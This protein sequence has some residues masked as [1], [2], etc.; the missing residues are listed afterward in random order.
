MAAEKT[1]LVVDDD[2]DIVETTRMILESAGYKVETAVNGTEGLAK[3]RSVHPD[4]II[5]DVM[6][7]KESEGFHVSY[8]LR[9]GED[10]KDIPILILSA[11]GQKSGFKFSPE[12]D[13]DYLPVD[14]YVEKP[15]EPKALLAKIEELLRK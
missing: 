5:L 2:P 10:T 12:T 14:S 1:V 4:A 13:G 7:D 9:Q 8:E 3:A 6:M 15:I 11:I